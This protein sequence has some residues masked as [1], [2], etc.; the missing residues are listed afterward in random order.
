MIRP[1]IITLAAMAAVASPVP[2]AAQ[3]EDHALV[4]R[5]KPA[6]VAGAI[7]PAF[8]SSMAEFLSV[9]CMRSDLVPCSIN[10][11]NCVPV[12]GVCCQDTGEG[13]LDKAS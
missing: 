7:I 9:K 12:W 5:Q 11:W 8:Y 1:L 4:A 3:V 10:R 13:P 6:L 2:D